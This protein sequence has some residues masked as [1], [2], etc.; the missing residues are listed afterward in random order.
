MNKEF[1]AGWLRFTRQDLIKFGLA[2]MLPVLAGVDMQTHRTLSAGMK[3]YTRI[4]PES[5]TLTVAVHGFAAPDIRKQAEPLIDVWDLHGD[6]LMIQAFGGLYDKTKLSEYTAERSADLMRTKKY[7]RFIMNGFS[8]GGNVGAD[9]L[10]LLNNNRT[11]ED[12]S[13]EPSAILFDTP[14]TKEDLLGPA[15]VFSPVAGYNAG[16]LSNLLPQY[17]DLDESFLIS[18]YDAIVSRSAPKP[19]SLDFLTRL[20]YW[21]S[22]QDDRMVRAESS[23]AKW[24]NTVDPEKFQVVGVDMPHVDFE[25]NPE[26][27][28][29]ALSGIYIDIL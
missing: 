27:S 11:F 29:A 1:D 4:S 10:V 23:I 13:V 21:Q 19:G 7:G 22:L 3:S 28:R 25:H 16:R 9:A 12:Y 18:Q 15:R 14:A 8:E 24:R 26:L 2:A 17:H 6:S 20:R 5:D